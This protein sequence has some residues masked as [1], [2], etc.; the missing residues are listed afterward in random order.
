MLLHELNRE[1]MVA[2][3]ELAHLVAKANGIIDEN[4]KIMLDTYKK[5]MGLENS[6]ELKDLQLEEI[7]PNFVHN[8]SKRIAFLESIS[9]AFADGIYHEEQKNLIAELRHAFE[10]SLEDYENFKA[11]IIKVNALHIQANEMVGA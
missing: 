9:V 11:W 3:L 1:E 4:E 2:F 10:I 6:Y 7:V 5:E 8:R